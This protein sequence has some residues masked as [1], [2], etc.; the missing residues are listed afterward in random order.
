M[1]GVGLWVFPLRQL[2]FTSNPIMQQSAAF[3]P[4]CLIH[5]CL[6]V[7]GG[8]RAGLQSLCMLCMLY[9]CMLLPVAGV[10]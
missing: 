7:C 6:Q 5:V 8:R 9:V 2:L 1:A 10:L 3:A 4:T